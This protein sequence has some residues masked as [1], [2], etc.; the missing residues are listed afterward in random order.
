LP[1]DEAHNLAHKRACA[2]QRNLPAYVGSGSSSTHAIE[3]TR[4]LFVRFTPKATFTNQD[5]IRRFVPRAAIVQ[6][7]LAASSW[8]NAAIAASHQAGDNSLRNA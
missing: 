7:I 1:S 5:L 2:S 3:A 8:A 4:P 6:V